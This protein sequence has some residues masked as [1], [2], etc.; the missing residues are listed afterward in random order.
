MVLL[1]VK[2]GFAM[3]SGKWRRACTGQAKAVQPILLALLALS[4]I[5]QRVRYCQ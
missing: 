2:F 4:E 5:M 1:T 3:M